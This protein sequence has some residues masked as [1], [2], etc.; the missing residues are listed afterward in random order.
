MEYGPGAAERPL[1]S[2]IITSYN[3]GRYIGEAIAS[4]LTQ[5]LRQLELIVVDNASTDGTDDVVATFLGDPRLRYIKNETNIGLTPNHNRGL[6]FARGEFIVFCSADDRLLPGHLRRTVDYLQAHPA[7]DMVYGGVVFMDAESAPL[8]VRSM[9]GQLPVDYDGGRNEF[10]AQLSSGCYVAWP[11]MVARRRLYDEL[12]P[13]DDNLK[14]ADYDITLRWAAAGKRFGYL[15]TPSVAIR[16]HPPQASGRSYIAEGH[17]LDEFL[18]T[19][20]KYV[21]PA[22]AGRVQGYI[23]AIARNVNGRLETYRK[24]SGGDTPDGV[25]ERVNAV[26]RRLAELPVL[27]LTDDLAGPLIS[28]IVRVETIPQLF[29]SLGSLAAQANAPAWEAIVVAEGGADVGALLRSLPY[30]ERVGFVRLD[31]STGPGAARNL[32]LQLAAGRIV[33]YLDP[34][35]AFRSNHLAGLAAAFASGAFIVRSNGRML[36]DETTDGTP[37]TLIRETPVTGLIRGAG[38]DDRDLVAANVPV[39]AI[40]HVMGTVERTGP[41][42]PDLPFGEVWEYW[43]RLRQLGVVYN[44]AGEVDV[45]VIRQRA[46]PPPAYLGVVQSLHNAYAA[47][48]ESPL[49]VRRAAYL[50]NLTAL[51][52]AGDAAIADDMKAIEAL[53]TMLGLE[54]AV[55]GRHD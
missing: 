15:R 7:T 41:F 19:V 13:L 27:P 6:S 38:D 31:H 42:R 16:L 53:A 26:L 47:P 48:A 55:A 8:G 32:G 10:A 54:N 5:D 22:Y 36:L 37:N 12:G 46:L 9:A 24:F 11:S 25:V 43:L 1:V 18:T 17:D 30:A 3:Y 44:P 21:V 40:A 14:A 20:E 45:R 34:G 4:V 2:V 33:T 49:A 52:E 28:V 39:E 35:N 51:I 29:I 23:N 50:R